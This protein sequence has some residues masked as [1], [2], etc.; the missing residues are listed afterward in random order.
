MIK[1]ILLKY[2][3][4]C[5]KFRAVEK[6]YSQVILQMQPKFWIVFLLSCLGNWLPLQAHTLLLE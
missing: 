6:A 2:I 1:T 4:Y 3:H 5:K